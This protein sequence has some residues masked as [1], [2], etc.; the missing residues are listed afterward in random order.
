MLTKWENKMI[1]VTLNQIKDA[2]QE[3]YLRE[4]IG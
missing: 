3:Q 4:L 2:A 1:T